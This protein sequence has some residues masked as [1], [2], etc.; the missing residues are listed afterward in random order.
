MRWIMS[1]IF[2]FRSLSLWA[3]FGLGG[4]TRVIFSM[5]HSSLDRAEAWTPHFSLKFF[6]CIH[7]YPLRRMYSV[8]TLHPS[9]LESTSVPEHCPCNLHRRNRKIRQPGIWWWGRPRCRSD[10]LNLEASPLSPF[11]F[12]SLLTSD[13]WSPH[14]LFFF[15]TLING[16]GMGC[17][18]DCD[19]APRR[20]A[21][22]VGF[23]ITF[24]V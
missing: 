9:N 4:S 5:V 3:I 18:S 23:P 14:H 17:D 1:A 13:W 6:P 12:F 20:A 15:Y 2:R 10:Q 19:G 7:M 16:Y 21:C 11:L 22:Q 24:C 8:P